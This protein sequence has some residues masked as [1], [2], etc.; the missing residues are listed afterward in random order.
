MYLGK[1]VVKLVELGELG[2]LGGLRKQVKLT[3]Q[4]DYITCNQAT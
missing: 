3:R 4:L 1:W 2:R